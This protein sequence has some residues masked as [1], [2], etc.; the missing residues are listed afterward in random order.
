MRPT[1][2]KNFTL[3]FIQSAFPARKS[4]QFVSKEYK[5]QKDP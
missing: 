5:S 2:E 3:Y 4:L 1:Q